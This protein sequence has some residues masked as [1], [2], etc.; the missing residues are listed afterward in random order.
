MVFQ[1]I[2]DTV[3]DTSIVFPHA[4]G[5]PFKKGLKK[6]ALDILEK[7]IQKEVG[8][9]NSTEDAIACMELMIW[10]VKYLLG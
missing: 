2:H 6:L 4:R 8:G 7:D 9:H 1:L 10:K 5:P 3:V